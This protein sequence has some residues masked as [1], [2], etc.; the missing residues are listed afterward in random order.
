MSK[1]DDFF[2]RYYDYK[3]KATSLLTEV[4]GVEILSFKEVKQ[5]SIIRY[6]FD[7]IG[8]I[9]DSSINIYEL[10][11]L[12]KEWLENNTCYD[13]MI[14]SYEVYLMEDIWEVS[15]MDLDTHKRFDKHKKWYLNL[16]EACQYV[17]EHKKEN[18]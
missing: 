8:E 15:V 11:H 9:R 17:L 16:F 2:I 6:K 3:E 7:C 18:K 4:L 12:C 10:A 13:V 14:I 5:T 1:E